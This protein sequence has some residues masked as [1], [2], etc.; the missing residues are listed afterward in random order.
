MKDSFKQSLRMSCVSLRKKL[1]AIEQAKASAAVCENIRALPAYVLAKRIALYRAVNGEI[2]LDDLRQSPTH[3]YYFPVIQEDKTLIFLP[4]SDESA[5]SR[6]KFGIL[7]P[8][9]SKTLAI[10]LNQIDIMFVPLIAF[11]EHG[12]RIGMGGGFY[13]RTLADERP[14]LL[15]GVAYEFQRQPF[16]EPSAWDVP[17]TAVITECNTYWSKS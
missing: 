16:I 1:P 11:D 13:D 5:F 2:D 9:S 17:L 6:N 4:A 15:I 10:A 8:N 7:E 14:P 12:T 3:T